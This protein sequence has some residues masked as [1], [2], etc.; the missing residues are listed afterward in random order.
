M[1]ANLS[2]T[3]RISKQ[4]IVNMYRDIFDFNISVGMVCKAERTVSRALA[5]PVNEAKSFVRSAEEVSVHS[6][7][8]GFKEKGKGM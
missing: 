5:A 4:N 6:D 8:T 2:G 7:E 1:T 3:Y